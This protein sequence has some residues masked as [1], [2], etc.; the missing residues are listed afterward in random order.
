M[1]NRFGSTNEIGVFEMKENGL[2]EVLDPS[3]L[4]L[5]ERSAGAS[6]STVVAALKGT[7]PYFGRNSGF[8]R[9]GNVWQPPQNG[10]RASI[11][12]GFR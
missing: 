4:F 3:E 5:D 8:D 12:I 10:D 11:T 6:G 1:K 7:R 9:T 2:E